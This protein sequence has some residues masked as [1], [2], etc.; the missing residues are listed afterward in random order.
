[1]TSVRYLISHALA[2]PL[3]AMDRLH[4]KCNIHLLGAVDK[5]VL[6]V[7][8][9]AGLYRCWDHTGDA[10]FMAVAAFGLLIFGFCGMLYYYFSVQNLSGSLMHLW[11]GCLFGLITFTNSKMSPDLDV[12]MTASDVIL[13]ASLVLKV[14]WVCVERLFGLVEYKLLLSE[15][16]FQSLGFAV[17]CVIC[18]AKILSLWLFVAGF[19]CL[20]LSLRLRAVLAFPC[21]GLFTSL[22]VAFFFKE[23]NVSFNYYAIACVTGRLIAEPLADNIWSRGLTVLERWHFLMTVRHTTGK[24]ILLAVMGL[25]VGFLVLSG[26]AA[27]NHDE[28]YFAIPAY[29]LFGFLWISLHI[30]FFIT[31]WTFISKFY[32]CTEI[33]QNTSNGTHETFGVI[34]AARG[35]RFFTLVA[36]HLV[37][38]TVISSLFLGAVTWQDHNT[39]FLGAWLA[40]LPIEVLIHGLFC[41]LGNTLGG[42]C[43]GLALV[44]PSSFCRSDGTTVP[45]PAS[46]LEEASTCSLRLL[47]IIQ[48]FFT[49]HMINVFSSDFSSS[50]LE[51]TFVETKLKSFFVTRTEDGPRYDTYI[52]YYS[53]HVYPNGNW[54]L[55]GDTSLAFEKL[56][57]WWTE[58]NKDFGSRLIII[59]DVTNNGSW[60][61]QVRKVSEHF[62]AL[63]CASVSK[64]TDPETG[65]K[66]GVGDFTRE[67][68]GF[69]CTIESSSSWKEQ[70]RK[71]KAM[72]AVSKRWS[73]FQFQMPT[74]WDME[75]HWQHNFPQST[76]PII[77]LLQ[78]PTSL[79]LC[80]VLS[81]FSSCIR[82]WKMKWMP[83]MILDTGHGFKLVR[84]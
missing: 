40:V 53:G 14:L 35:L 80:S 43:T 10:S 60:L 83:P 32:K 66:S 19:V 74:E 24:L 20:L 6:M 27:F 46:S 8:V 13:V 72:Y 77:R 47:H 39:E 26:C 12:P 64:S 3:K 54:A 57:D 49:Y 69:N 51:I 16:L 78:I 11:V 29:G 71:V 73:D 65:V 55:A 59:Q 17:A 81:V 48:H 68:V 5:M 75:Q 4:L 22:S 9:C 25:E 63:Q 34:M 67:W 44:G 31:C 18:T 42:T 79:D 56:L 36:R 2:V 38:S 62:V 84:S 21:L 15:E 1:M 30:V 7:A 45:V 33:Y 23:V 82:R 37:L 70:G 52:L 41:E 50:G 58:T 28:W 61:K 76:H